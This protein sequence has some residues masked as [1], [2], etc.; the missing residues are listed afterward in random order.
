MTAA[1]A[2][3]TLHLVVRAVELR[4]ADA[5]DSP[6][7]SPPAGTTVV[8]RGPALWRRAGG[9]LP[10]GVPLVERLTLDLRARTP[11]GDVRRVGP[12]G[13]APGHARHVEALPDDAAV[14]ATDGWP[15]RARWP[16]AASPRFPAAG[17]REAAPRLCVPLGVDALP[18]DWLPAVPPPG[19]ALERDGL[20]PFDAA[21]FADP[22]LAG[23]AATTLVDDATWRRDH[24]SRP[25]DAPDVPLRPLALHAALDVEEVTLVA[26][27]DAVQPGWERADVGA[28]LPPAPSPA[29]DDGRCPP[30]DFRA[31][32]LAT[33]A[34]PTLAAAVQD[35]GAVALG[36]TADAD[37]GPFVVE[38]AASREWRDAAPVYEGDAR[39][40][41]LPARRAGDLHY[42]VRGR[43]PR[44]TPWSH[45]V[46]VRVGPPLGWRVRTRREY[47]DDVLL[48]AHR[49]LLRV[50]AARRDLLAVLALPAH[51]RDDD[52]AAHVRR[53]TARA[54]EADLP[55]DGATV[56]VPPLGGVER[57]APGFAALY[58][59][60]LV[61]RD[62][63]GGL[64][65]VAPDGTLCGAIAR[66]AIA[67]GAWVAPAN[68]PLAGIVALARPG[69][70]AGPAAWARLQALQ[71]NVVRHEPRG[72]LVLAA[73]T[74]ADDDD[75]RPIGVRRLLILL[76]R[77]AT[78]LG[79]TY[80]FEPHD[81]AFRRAVQRGFEGLLGDLFRRG[82]LAGRTAD[83]A[84]QVVTG[85]TLNTPASVEQGR[86]LV[87]LRVAPSRPMAFL[88]VRLV[89]TG[90]RVVATEG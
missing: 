66:R 73:D 74:L 77:V 36:W 75:V 90:E 28:P 27:P 69:D 16:D 31:C 63:D 65:A 54:T 37:A 14:H 52:A 22:A 88:T 10:P 87:E 32:A 9:D 72:F 60:W 81:D 5:A 62:D 58:H 7:D 78:R 68:E 48:A 3:A 6:P 57:D 56:W 35:G 42:R 19:T 44:A 53:L 20:V 67:R 38:E 45:G 13:L 17:R 83:A 84:F 29:P 12:L 80:V 76:R 15:D 71:V 79:A 50:G 64:R 8:V 1:F 47:R 33:G 24:A 34:A 2:G 59:G 55:D 89:Q 49:V 46:A 39:T 85:E 70:A 51:Y 21:L 82:A 4:R 30:D 25:A 41:L 61:R 18:A 11:E 40:V 86:F 26:A 43:G 23:S